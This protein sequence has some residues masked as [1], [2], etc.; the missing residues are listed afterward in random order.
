M[1]QRS[2]FL[3]SRTNFICMHKLSPGLLPRLH[4]V[5]GKKFFFT[6]GGIVVDNVVSPKPYLSHGCLRIENIHNFL[7]RTMAKSMHGSQL[8]WDD[9]LSL[10]TY[11]CN[12]VSSVDDLES[13]FYVVNG[14]DPLKG[15]LSNLQN[16]CKYIRDQPS[17]LAVQKLE[18]MWK[19]C[20]KLLEENSR[21]DLAE[22]KKISKA[23]NLKIDQLVF[24]KDHCKGTFE[25]TNIYDHR[26]SGILNDCTVI[27]N[28]PDGKEK[29]YNIHHIKHMIP[30]LMP[31]ISFWMV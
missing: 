16:Y 28:T 24:V 20:T 8:K 31:L 25:P 18:K 14:R 12:I 9:A 27:F 1:T 21:A 5:C 10:A 11:F 26:V 15:R 7:K 30:V 23:N 19:L 22:N 17:Q 2:N 29:K 4:Q 6:T 13:P 3:L